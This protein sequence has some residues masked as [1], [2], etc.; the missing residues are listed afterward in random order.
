LIDVSCAMRELKR[1]VL[2]QFRPMRVRL[3]WFSKVFVACHGHMK[4]YSKI[5]IAF[6]PLIQIVGARLFPLSALVVGSLRASLTC[7]QQPWCGPFAC[8]VAKKY[9]SAFTVK[10]LS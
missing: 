9:D 10:F 6:Y 4:L 3:S 8:D 5:E 2:R 7:T 1:V